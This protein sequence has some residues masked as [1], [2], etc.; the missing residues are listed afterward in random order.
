MVIASGLQSLRRL[1]LFGFSTLVLAAI[2]GLCSVTARAAEKGLTLIPL[3]LYFKRGKVK[4]EL[5]LMRGK[6]LWD[7]RKTIAERD[8]KRELERALN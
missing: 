1:R 2:L 7:K 6:K 8:S 4:V 5:G 3:R